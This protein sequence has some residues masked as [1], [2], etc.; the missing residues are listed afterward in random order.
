MFYFVILCVICT[1]HV[2]EVQLLSE[3]SSFWTCNPTRWYFGH[4]EG[5]GGAEGFGK[6][7][8]QAATGALGTLMSAVKAVSEQRV[9]VPHAVSF[10]KVSTSFRGIKC[11]SSAM[12]VVLQ[13]GSAG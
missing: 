2:T 6:A 9:T 7:G 5:E 8:R 13:V 11:R 10:R 12:L 1:Q 3:K 4:C